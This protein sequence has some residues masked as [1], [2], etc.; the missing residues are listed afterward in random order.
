MEY[1]PVGDGFGGADFLYSRL[2][3]GARREARPTQPARAIRPL[4]GHIVFEN[5]WFAYEGEHWVLRDFSLEIKP[6]NRVGVVGHTGAGK[7]TII[8][9][10]MRFY[11]PQRGRI[12]LDGK[13]LREY[14][15]R[16]LRAAIGIIQQDVFLF[17]GSLY[18]N[19]TFWN[20]QQLSEDE[21]REI[22]SRS[23][24]TSSGFRITDP[25]SSLN[26]EGIS[27]WARGRSCIH[28]SAHRQTPNL[29]S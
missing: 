16:D 5:V 17:S 10:L 18:E 6:G 3:D 28:S 9:L 7:T 23:S 13:D 27:R 2:A 26:V 25:R 24:G 14:A 8:S 12:L 20:S 19:M 21:I 4:Q 15:K 29:D 11:E 1:L 22:A